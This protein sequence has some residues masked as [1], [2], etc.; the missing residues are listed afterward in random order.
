MKETELAQHFVEY[1]SCYDLYF[2]VES[3][4]GRV[5][6]V[7]INKPLRI[8]Y[9]VKTSFNFK[10]LE[11]A[12]NN[13]KYFHYSYIA[14]PYFKNNYFQRDLC[15][16]YGVGLI[17]CNANGWMNGGFE[18]RVKP[19][20]NRSPFNAFRYELNDSYKLSI[21]GS[22]GAEGGRVTPFKITVENIVRH[23]KHHPGCSIKELI[24]EIQHH[25]SSDAGEKSSIYQH[26]NS[27][28]IKEIRLE[29]GKL[30]L[31]DIA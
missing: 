25:Y 17:T 5:D 13:K 16:D 21:P 10:V 23:V 26:I 29:K 9:E 2:E 20:L 12:I 6:I 3:G 11:Q 14:V 4:A 19:K 27:D 24:S 7:A 22:S 1:L 18:E 15:K 28:I 30:Y 31:T 8:A